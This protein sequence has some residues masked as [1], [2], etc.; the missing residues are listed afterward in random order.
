MTKTGVCGKYGMTR[1]ASG[2]GVRGMLLLCGVLAGSLFSATASASD[3]AKMVAP[4]FECHGEAG[5]STA[6]EVPSIAGYS[7]EYFSY[8]LQ[9]YQE[10]DRPCIDAEFRTGSKKGQRTSM[11][12]IVKGMTDSD[13]ETMAEYFAARKFVRSE[14]AFDA[15][16]AGKGKAIHRDKCDECHGRSGSD[17]KDDACILAG[18]KIAYLREQLRFVRN[19]QRFTSKKMKA[20]LQTMSDDDIEAV[21]HYYASFR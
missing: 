7:E 10:G 4:C 21:I 17:P 1:A 15:G 19:G 13:F 16:L 14:Q 8:S 9:M 5:V 11:C 18:Q 6:A 20:R 3:V 12:E 2:A